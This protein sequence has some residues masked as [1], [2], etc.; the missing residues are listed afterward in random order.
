M[1]SSS[2]QYIQK[3]KE[4][5]KNICNDCLDEEFSMYVYRLFRFAISV[6]AF[7]NSMQMYAMEL[8]VFSEAA[9]PFVFLFT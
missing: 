3:Q 7:A 6:V 8:M 5:T 4:T 2:I 1:F 9:K